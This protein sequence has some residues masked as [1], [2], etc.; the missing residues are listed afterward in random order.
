MKEEEIES[1]L[2]GKCMYL[3]AALHRTFGWEI[4]ATLEDNHSPYIGH[5][6]CIVPETGE[7][8]DID[9]FYPMSRNGWL[10]PQSELIVKLNEKTLFALVQSTSYSSVTVQEWESS[11]QD[12]MDVVLHYFFKNN[13]ITILK[14]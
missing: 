6:W 12:A 5:T 1:Y 3:A 10:S 7:C 4:Q 2:S 8:A 14:N 13:K 9:G 11:V